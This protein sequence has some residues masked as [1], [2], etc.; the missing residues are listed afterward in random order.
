MQRALAAVGKRLRALRQERE[1]TLTGLSAQTGISVSTLS[2]LESGD[3]RPTLE[4]L[5]PLAR[6]Y[7]PTPD[8]LADA[9]S[10]ADPGIHLRP[11]KGNGMTMV[12]STRR[13]DGTR[14]S[15]LVIPAGEA[16]Q[17]NTLTSRWFGAADEGPVEF[18]SLLGGQQGEPTHPG[19]RPRP[20]GKP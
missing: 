5:L 15:K 20:S 14:A 10:T 9:P 18:L 12:P 11:V 6:A 16:P 7:G 3:R 17:F 2:Q 1:T 19:A 4:R 13:A 8:E